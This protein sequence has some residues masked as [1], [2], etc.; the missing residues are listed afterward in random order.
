RANRRLNAFKDNLKEVA[1]RGE[2]AMDSELQKMQRRYNDMK[3]ELETY[4]NNLLFLTSSSKKGNS[5]I[6]EMN[7]KVEK[8]RDELNLTKEKIKAMKE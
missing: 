1:K 8:L 5:L 2:G 7:R 4:E 3:Q 6:D